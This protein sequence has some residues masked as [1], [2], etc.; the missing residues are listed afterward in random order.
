MK[1]STPILLI[2][3]NRPEATRRVFEVIRKVKP[4]KLYIAADGPRED[5]LGE[6]ELCRMTRE[7]VSSIDWPCEVKRLYQDRNLGCKIGV[8]S[9]ITW[10]FQNVEEGIILEDDCLPVKSFFPYCSELLSQYRNDEQIMHINGTNPLSSDEI[11]E[12]SASYYFSRSAQV[13]GW[14]TWRRAWEQYDISM[15]DLGKLETRSGSQDLFS[16]KKH[17]NFWIKHFKHIQNKDVDTWDAQ[18][19]YSILN[20]NGY[21]IMPNENLIEN[22]GFGPGATHTTNLN[23]KTVSVS[24][25]RLPLT[26]PAII[27]VDMQADYKLMNKMFIRNIWQ[28]IIS[29]SKLKSLNS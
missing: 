23:Y 29:R 20:N 11:G 6:T 15:K 1:Y 22:I 5:R 16:N 2:I 19:Q 13:W 9:A 3:F 17:F 24:E 25:I 12:Q 28:R 18:W 14:A 27:K 21:V 10:F 8:S 4:E 7:I 26:H